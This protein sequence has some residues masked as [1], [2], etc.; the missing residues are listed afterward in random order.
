MIFLRQW[1]WAF[2]LIAF[3]LTS[4]YASGIDNGVSH[5]RLKYLSIA[6]GMYHSGNYF[7]PMVMGKC[8]PTNRPLYFG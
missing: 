5:D 6:W 4:L 1:G 3:S 7:I 2:L 8:I